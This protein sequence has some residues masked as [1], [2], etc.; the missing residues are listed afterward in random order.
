MF[1][2]V[3]LTARSANRHTC[4]TQGESEGGCAPEMWK[5]FQKSLENEVTLVQHFLIKLCNIRLEM[6]FHSLLKK[7]DLV[8]LT[9]S[10]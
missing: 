6:P 2:K 5:I 10:V 9:S 4:A 8:F 7:S 3:G 1:L